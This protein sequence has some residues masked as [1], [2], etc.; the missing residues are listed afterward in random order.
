MFGKLHAAP[1]SA[2]ALTL[3]NS[4]HALLGELSSKTVPG[5]LFIEIT[6][7]QIQLRDRQWLCLHT[8]NLSASV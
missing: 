3:G 7:M 6:R 8:G 1:I 2:M 4:M 5:V